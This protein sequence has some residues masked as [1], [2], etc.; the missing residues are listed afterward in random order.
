MLYML[1]NVTSSSLHDAGRGH[2]T[3]FLAVMGC[4]LMGSAWSSVNAFSGDVGLMRM[5]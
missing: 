2:V 4:C 3:Y 1:T 5:P